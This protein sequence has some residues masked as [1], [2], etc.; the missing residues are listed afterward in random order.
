MNRLLCLSFNDLRLTQTKIN[1]ALIHKQKPR[2]EK[3]KRLIYLKN[4]LR[5]LAIQAQKP[6]IKILI[7]P[8]ALTSRL[9]KN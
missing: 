8:A 9:A 4:R 1:S 7:E 2:P 6:V 5:I 3:L